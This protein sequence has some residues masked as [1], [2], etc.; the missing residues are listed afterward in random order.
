MSGISLSED[1]VNIFY[2]VRSKSK[3]RWVLWRINDEMTEVVI[4]KLG[5][6]SSSYGDF[7]AALPP[8]DCRYA[9]FDYAFVGGD[10][11]THSKLVFINWA[12][13]VAKVKSKMMYAST[14]DFFKSNLEGL[15]LE[16]QGSDFDEVDEAT[17]GEA[18]RALKRNY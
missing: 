12:P 17:V 18:V 5:D 9:V 11:Q 4:E 7:L 1:A 16:F 14:K 13:D 2:L 3:Y 8:D 6:P 15:S 10:G